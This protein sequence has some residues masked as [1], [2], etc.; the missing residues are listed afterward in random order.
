MTGPLLTRPPGSAPETL[1]SYRAAG[2]YEA[3][4]LALSEGTP[5]GVVREIAES[6]L[7]GRGGAGFPTG[8]KWELAAASEGSPRYVVAN[9]GEH[10]PGSRKDRLLV[11][12]YPHKVLEGIAL[13]AYATG[14]SEAWIYL[15]E[16]MAE[17]LASARAAIDEARAA[18]LLGPSVLGTPFALEVRVEA[19]P[20]TYVAGEETAALEV[21]EG[22]KAWPRKKPP[23][24][25]VSGLFGKPTTVNN[26][27]TLAHAPGIV[28]R[29]A[30]WFRGLGEAGG[31]GTMLFTLDERVA[32]PGVY[33][34]PLGSTYRRLIY[35]L[36]G[37]PRSGRPIRAILPAL[38]SSFLPADALDLPLTPEA[39]KEAGSGLGC[40]GVSF[41]EEGECLVCRVAGI[42]GFFM[43][44]QCGQCPPCRMETNTLAAVLGQVKAGTAG[45]YAAQIEKITTFARGKG[46]CSLI[47]M[48]AAPVL[49]ALRLFPD[50]FASHARTGACPA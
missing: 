33:E 24:P 9:G 28:R 30:A 21:I 16:D 20:T 27:E 2:G 49:S 17:A 31:A 5:A 14:A 10:E 11:T 43:A 4:R 6:G 40:G 3:L 19:A 47:E 38:S 45:D 7:R 34:R 50:D 41:V 46:Y 32:R 26:I 44:E 25:G 35:D 13:C 37:G 29:G 15:I 8:R 36:G 12:E 18:G 1:A 48:A 42:A 22:R 39:L 23:Y